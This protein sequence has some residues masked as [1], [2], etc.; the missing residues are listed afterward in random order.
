MRKK[1]VI[2]AL[3][4]SRLVLLILFA[5][6]FFC[7]TGSAEAAIPKKGSVAIVVGGVDELHTMS[8]QSIFVRDLRAS[9][10]KVVDEKTLNAMRKSEA[11]RL[12]LE[13][14]V[15]AIMKLSSKYGVSTFITAYI[16][17][18]QP[19]VNEF[20]LYTGTASIA[21]QARSGA[22]MIYGDTVSGKQVGY[23]PDE[24]AQKAIETAAALAAKKLAQ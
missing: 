9:G 15:D 5:A 6:A 10:Y 21:I 22:N 14:N 20:Q 1:K 11:G 7:G 23:T 19:V 17:A 16:R 8:A 13:G 2:S 3:R 24:A 18:G 12:A 4:M